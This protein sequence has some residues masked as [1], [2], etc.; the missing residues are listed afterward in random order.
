[1]KH[2]C[3]EGPGG[4]CHLTEDKPPKLIAVLCELLPVERF[5]G[6]KR[7][8]QGKGYLNHYLGESFFIFQA[9]SRRGGKDG[10]VGPAVLEIL[11]FALTAAS[12]KG[13]QAVSSALRSKRKRKK[14]WAL[15]T[16]EIKIEPR[17]STRST[18]GRAMAVFHPTQSLQVPD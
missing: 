4:A 18:S 6:C 10:A 11:L 3:N 7:Q 14:K 2:K 5:V 8:P 17:T 1:M 15:S 16:G 13:H 9:D 12:R